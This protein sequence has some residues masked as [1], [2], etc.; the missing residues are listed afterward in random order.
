MA[1]DSQ[2]YIDLF[3]Q[4]IGRKPEFILP[5]GIFGYD[6]KY[7]NPYRDN[8]LAKAKQLLSEAGYPGGIDPKTGDRLTI[9]YDNTATDAAGRQ[10]V[11]LLQKFLDSI[12][13]KLVSRPWRDIIWQDKVDNGQFQMIT[14]GWVAD[15][16]D[17]E[18]FL[19][20]FYSKNLRPGPNHSGYNNPAYDKLFEKMRAMNDGPERLAIINRMRAIAVEDCPLVYLEHS[21]SLS[22]HYDWLK[23]VKP[24][25]ISNDFAKYE[26]VDGKY[27]ARMQE[28][29]NKP[30]YWPVIGLFVFLI[31]GSLPA[32][33][34]VNNHKRR[35]IRK[36]KG[37]V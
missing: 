6:P 27:R 34:I 21:E 2:S 36:Q 1:I 22:I 19:F 7:K 12:G 14:Y 25:P 11:G 8:N 24:H 13:I 17:P 29:W 31:L 23:N 18:N 26:R 4:G 3:S 33:Y 20:L 5:P 37:N 30:V 9:Y 16:P 35:H 28:E 10:V 32:I 15:Y